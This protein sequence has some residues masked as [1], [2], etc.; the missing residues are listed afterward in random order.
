MQ[1][2]GHVFKKAGVGRDGHRCAA[3]GQGLEKIGNPYTINGIRYVPIA[4]STGYKETGIASWYGADF[5]GKPTAN[6]ECYDM[7]AISAAHNTLPMPT[8]VRVTHLENGRS[9]VLRVNDR[10]PF[11][12]GRLIDLSYGAASKLGMVK[13]GTAPVSVEAV[14][15]PFHDTKPHT[16]LAQQQQ[17]QQKQTFTERVSAPKAP[18]EPTPERKPSSPPTDAVPPNVVVEDLPPPPQNV[19]KTSFAHLDKTQIYVQTGAF[20]SLKNAQ[21]Q[22]IK[23]QKYGTA[24]LMQTNKEGRILHRVRFGPFDNIASG[25]TALAK[26]VNAG[27]NTAILVIEEQSNQLK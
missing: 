10:G 20:S 1:L 22:L 6:G 3:P 9:I 7:Y 11:A 15:G 27:F 24:H 12:R 26:M 19:P 8:W 17:P 23:V 14:S 13:Q 21:Q 16:R 18:A 25:D 5:H 4:R 2:A